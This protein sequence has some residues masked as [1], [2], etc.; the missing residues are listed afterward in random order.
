MGSKTV[1]KLF[2]AAILIVTFISFYPC[3]LGGFVNFDD[4]RY[5][6][7]NPMIK[8]LSW[9]G[10][11]TIFTSTDYAVVYCPLVFLS[12]AIEYHFFGLRPYGYHVTNLILHLCNCLLVFWFISLLCRDRPTAFITALLFGVHPLRAE[13]VAWITERKDLLYAFFFLWALI[14]YCDRRVR[15]SR[16]GYAGVVLFFLLSLLSKPTA[17][18][19][20][21]V[22]LL[23][24]YFQGKKIDRRNLSSKLPLFAIAAAFLILGL[25][26]ARGYGRMGPAFTMFDQMFIPPYALLFYLYKSIVP[27]G[28]SCLYPFPVKHGVFLPAKFLLS[29][30]ALVLLGAIVVR[31]MRHTKTIAFGSLFFLVTIA[32]A[33]Q[34]FPTGTAIVADRFTYIPSI[35]LSFMVA[36]LVAWLYTK[37]DKRGARLATAALVAVVA[38]MAVL[39]WGRCGVWNSSIALW[40]DTVRKYPDD[41]VPIAYFNRGIV[42][43]DMGLHEKAVS[44]FNKAL[45]LYYRERGIKR[46]YNEYCLGILAAGGGPAEVYNFM[47]SKYAEIG[48]TQEAIGCLNV[49][50]RVRD[51]QSAPFRM[52]P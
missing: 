30:L 44:D 13:S 47:A 36:G 3:L 18:V 29:P 16:I 38:A 41:Y 31:S 7:R 2:V 26:T 50:K 48:K 39:T 22:L 49:S 19:L 1:T 52:A 21:L 4:D 10:I 42:Y 8:E 35:G 27:L 43:S 32:P 33:L 11:G 15:E 5:V 17:L 40:E 28:L 14:C 25:V 51:R 24:D 12:Y 20:P 34:F 46:D 23:C 6:Y 37:K 45:A 9:Q